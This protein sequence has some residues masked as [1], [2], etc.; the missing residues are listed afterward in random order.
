MTKKHSK[1]YFP[2]LSDEQ[3]FT[4]VLGSFQYILSYT[5]NCTEKEFENEL[6]IQDAVSY[7][8]VCIGHATQNLYSNLGQKYADFPW[9]LYFYIDEN[10]R[11]LIWELISSESDSDFDSIKSLFNELEQ[12]YFEE[13]YPNKTNTN[14]EIKRIKK[15]KIISSTDYKYPTKTSKSIWTVRKK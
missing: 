8:L 9:S 6:F 1:K 7:R 12:L 3:L 14:K 2:N 11:D 5:E 15:K 13:F 4:Y 10:P